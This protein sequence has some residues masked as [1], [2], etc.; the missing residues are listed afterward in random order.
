M[1]NYYVVCADDPTSHYTLWK[2]EKLFDDSNEINY[3]D[4]IFLKNLN[5]KQYLT[6]EYDKS[7]EVSS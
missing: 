5:T 4:Y 3:G 6:Y 2:V 1:N 7:S